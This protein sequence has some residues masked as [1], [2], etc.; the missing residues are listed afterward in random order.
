MEHLLYIKM[1]RAAVLA[2][3]AA[4]VVVSGCGDDDEYKNENRPPSLIVV[5]ASISDSRV[6]VSPSSFGAG[7]VNLIISNQSDSAQRVTFASADGTGFKQETGP[8][9]PGANAEL[10]VDVTPGAAVV[11][12]DGDGIQPARLKIGPARRTAQNE[13][14]QP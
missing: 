7:P 2:V 3:A 1:R 10:K 11:R 13:L 12:V 14:L 5:P 6:S 9:N 4:A 8:I